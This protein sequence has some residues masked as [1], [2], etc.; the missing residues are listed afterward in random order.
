[1]VSDAETDNE[2]KKRTEAPIMTQVTELIRRQADTLQARKK[3]NS[4]ILYGNQ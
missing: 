1:M 3:R 2:D 4:N